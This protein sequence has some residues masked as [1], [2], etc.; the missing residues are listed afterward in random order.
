[1]DFFSKTHI[2]REWQCLQYCPEHFAGRAGKDRANGGQ[3]EL[4]SFYAAR[5]SSA[6]L[7]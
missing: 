5:F 2:P 7:N 6:D 4:V 3:Y 1:V